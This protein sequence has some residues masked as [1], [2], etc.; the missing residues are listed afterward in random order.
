[1]KKLIN[2]IKFQR[3][4][5]WT[6]WR[7]EVNSISGGDWENKLMSPSWSQT[8]HADSGW[9]PG[10]HPLEQTVRLG[11]KRKS[12]ELSSGLRCLLSPAWTHLRWV[13]GWA[14]PC[15]GSTVMGTPR[16]GSSPPGITS[17]LSSRALWSPHLYRVGAGEAGGSELQTCLPSS[18]RFSS[19]ARCA[20]QGG[21]R[22]RAQDTHPAPSSREPQVSVRWRG[23]GSLWERISTSFWWQ[24]SHFQGWVWAKGPW[25]MQV[26][27]PGS[28]GTHIS[29]ESQ[30]LGGGQGGDTDS[31]VMLVK[32]GRA[33]ELIWGVSG[34]EVL[35]L[36]FWLPSRDLSQTHHLGWDSF[37]Q[38][39]VPTWIHHMLSWN[40]RVSTQTIGEYAAVGPH[41][42]EKEMAMHSSILAWK[43]PCTLEPASL[44]SIG[45]QWIRHDWVTSFSFILF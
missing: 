17:C 2:K 22:R 26:C 14:A 1:M 15:C 27:S 10:S 5:L 40:M 21:D 35:G 4:N 23:Q 32:S 43:I 28:P 16:S 11:R 18:L 33:P 30:E 9:E 36:S 39:R 12:W 3:K 8:V 37:G 19:S 45:L 29:L 6:D 41:Y 13:H 34:G 25:T 44:Q 42:L 31:R 7:K 38:L 20:G 24:I